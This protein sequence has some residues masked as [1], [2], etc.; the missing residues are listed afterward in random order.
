M[1]RYTLEATT[2]P[3]A[4]AHTTTIKIFELNADIPWIRVS[5]RLAPQ[6]GDSKIEILPGA[7]R[8]SGFRIARCAIV[9]EKLRVMGAYR[10]DS[11]DLQ[12]IKGF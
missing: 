9:Q 10:P 2:S 12:L 7:S 8:R 6:N 3:V 11:Q 4:S 5:T 1:L